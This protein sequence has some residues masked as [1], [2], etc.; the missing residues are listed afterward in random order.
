MRFRLR[1]TNT[2]G[3]KNL[4]IAHRA[5]VGGLWAV[6]SLLVA[7][8]SATGS[9]VQ[10]IALG[11][12]ALSVGL[13]LWAA[14]STMSALKV[15]RTGRPGTARVEAIEEV[16][17]LQLPADLRSSWIDR[18]QARIVFTDN[19]GHVHKTLAHPRG[20]FGKLE[21][22]SKIGVYVGPRRSWWN[23]DVGTRTTTQDFSKAS[24]GQSQ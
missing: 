23:G 1:R 12:T 21:H 15:R 11:V 19:F 2:P 13:I 8:A 9:A 10:Y 18:S 6:L 14:I 4:L 16:L 3:A 5:D 7:G 20:Y 22:G 24:A 17:A